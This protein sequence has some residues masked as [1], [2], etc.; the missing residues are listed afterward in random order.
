MPTH[1][2]DLTELSITQLAALTGCAKATTRSRLNAKGV[3]PVREDGRTLYYHPPTALPVILGQGEGLNP[4]AEK[5]RLD[6]V[7]ADL[8]DEELKRI[9]GE[10]ATRAEWEAATVALASALRARLLAVPAQIAAEVAAAGGKPAE[11]HAIIE[12][13]QLEALGGLA[14]ATPEAAPRRRARKSGGAGGARGRARKSQAAAKKK[15]KGV[16]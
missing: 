8:K 15:R 12:R 11:C 9:R 14:K 10:T 16:G 1:G 13:A 5:A 3:K 6:R 2:P 7:S 4:Q